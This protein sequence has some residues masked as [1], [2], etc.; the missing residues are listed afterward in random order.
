MAGQHAEQREHSACKEQGLQTVLGY[1]GY[2]RMSGN[3]AACTVEHYLALK[4]GLSLLIMSQW[5]FI[6]FNRLCSYVGDAQQI[7]NLLS[8]Q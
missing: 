3:T 8:A 7:W 5:L 6:K 2:K 1:K 4:A